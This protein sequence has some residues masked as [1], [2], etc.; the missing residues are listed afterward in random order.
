VTGV[1]TCALPISESAEGHSIL[2]WVFFAKNQTEAAIAE[3][4]KAAQIE[5]DLAVRHYDLARGYQIAKDYVKA[6]A[7]FQRAIA[8]YSQSAR[9]YWRLGDMAYEQK[10]YDQAIGYYN[11]VVQINGDI[12]TGYWGL[13]QAYYAQGNCAQAMP[14]YQKTIELNP[15]ANYAMTYLGWCEY[16]ADN[17]AVA[18]DWVRKAA[19]L[20]PNYADTKALLA[21]LGALVTPTPPIPP[22]LYVTNLRLEPP[23][24]GRA[25]DVSFLATFLNTTGATQ[26]YRWL[27]Y[28]YKAENLRNTFGET[29][30][31]ATSIP[32]GAAEQKALGTWRT[33][34]GGC[35]NFIAR[36]VWLDENRKATPFN[37][38]DGQVFELAFK[39][40]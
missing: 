34:V 1:Q 11:Q 40:C 39:V 28:I 20:D 22:G 16:K 19:A 36:V 32:V 26:N 29:A 5:P 25:Q 6:T 8:L 30:S 37:R 10:Q 27:V 12:S 9:A 2:G 14:A 7:A 38:P 3:F 18:L 35:D 21:A 24:P 33:S 4:A 13:G 17:F 15:K 23:V 31:I